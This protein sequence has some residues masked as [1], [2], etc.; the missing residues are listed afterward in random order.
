[1]TARILAP[2]G[3]PAAF[4]RHRR[5]NEPICDPCRDADA[6]RRRGEKTTE[7]GDI[8]V[9]V[10]RDKT[11]VITFTDPMDARI[12]ASAIGDRAYSLDQAPR[13]QTGAKEAARRAHEL[14]KKLS[15]QLREKGVLS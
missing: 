5:R 2:C 9:H 15:R 13:G 8:T 7:A 14:H 11:V 3:T 1:M 6:A 12:A 4:A 10:R